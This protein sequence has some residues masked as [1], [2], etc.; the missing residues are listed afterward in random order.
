MR[1]MYALIKEFVS[2]YDDGKVHSEYEKQMGKNSVN[3]VYI[4]MY[5]RIIELRTYCYGPIRHSL[6]L[7]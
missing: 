6:L 1:L 4:C 7:S 5:V 3:G 2:A